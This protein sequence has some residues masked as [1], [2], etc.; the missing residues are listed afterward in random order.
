MHMCLLGVKSAD[1]STS[2]WPLLEPAWPDAPNCYPISTVKAL[3]CLGPDVFRISQ[4]S[5]GSPH[6]L[7]L[8]PQDRTRITCLCDGAFAHLWDFW[9]P[10]SLFAFSLKLT[11]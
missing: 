9:L 10:N 6:L 1:H 4:G 7:V 3:Y 11:R 5:C 8:N 2:D